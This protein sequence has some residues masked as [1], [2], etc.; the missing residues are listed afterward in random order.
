VT[1]TSKH[2]RSDR[3]AASGK[4]QRKSITAKKKLHV[5]NR[6]ERN[7]HTVDIANAMGIPKS[8]SRSTRKQAD[9][10]KESCESAVR[11]MASKITQ[12][13][14]PITEKLERMLAQWTEH[15][16]CAIPLFTMIIQVTQVNEFSKHIDTPNGVTDN[17]DSNGDRSAKVSRVI[18]C[19]GLLQIT[20][21]ESKSFT[22]A[23]CLPQ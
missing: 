11:M 15:H 1:I 20:T 2:R 14:V 4:K 5:I 13:T 3:S 9:K 7:K 19:C 8:T 16:Q 22:S 23:L 12:I 21:A 10:I 17:N 6:Y 18:E